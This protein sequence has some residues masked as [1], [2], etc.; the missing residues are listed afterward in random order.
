MEKRSLFDK[1]IFILL[2]TIVLAIVMSVPGNANAA[3]PKEIEAVSVY[4]TSNWDPIADN[5]PSTE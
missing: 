4:A 2:M 1:R 3:A 5:K